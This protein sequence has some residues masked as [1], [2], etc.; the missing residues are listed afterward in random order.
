MLDDELEAGLVLASAVLAQS[1]TDKAK[2]EMAELRPLEEKTENRE[3]SLRFSLEQGGILLAENDLRSSR[4][5]VEMV[6]KA[7]ESSGYAEIM[8]EAQMI[9]ADMQAKSDD[10][11]G[12]SRQ[13]SLLEARERSAGLL[14]LARK[15]NTV[16]MRVAN[17]GKPPHTTG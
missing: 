3:L 17:A 13:L 10:K 15:T 9:L 11:A 14:L 8:Q 4:T 16:H 2:T 5:L 7:A 1:K 12:A 6:S